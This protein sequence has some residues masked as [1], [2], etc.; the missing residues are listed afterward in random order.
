MHSVVELEEEIL[1]L[2]A[3]ERE[4]LATVA[5]ESLFGDPAAA[6]DRSID[7]EGL[8]I[9]AQRDSEIELGQVLAIDHAEF[10]RRTAGSSR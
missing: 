9:A 1:A 3:A 8:Q 10:R 4:R 6:P 5:W 7:P 2:P